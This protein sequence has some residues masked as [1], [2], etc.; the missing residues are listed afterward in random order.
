MRSLVLIATVATVAASAVARSAI[1]A[2]QAPN[3]VTIGA[4]RPNLAFTYRYSDTQGSTEFTN[5]WEEFTATG[6]R[7][8]T[9]RSGANAGSST[10]VS[11]HS[12]VDDLF[13]LESSTAT[14]TDGGG[15][16]RNSMTYQPA[17]MGDPA[18]RVCEGR[19]WTIPAV[20]VTSQSM[21]GQFSSRTDPGTIRIVAIRESVTVPAG[22]FQTVR[23]TKTMNSGRGQVLDEFWKSIEHGVTVKRNGAVPGAVATEVLLSIR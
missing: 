3:C 7:L 9:T 8:V 4:P 6:S 15:P 11:R 21:R 10:Y 18:F 14:G 13:V 22:T 12:V 1:V 20:G 5:R 2:G 19:T 17:A 16:F 23:Y